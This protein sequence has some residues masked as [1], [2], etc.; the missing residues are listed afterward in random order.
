MLNYITY[1]APPEQQS[2]ILWRTKIFL[3]HMLILTLGYAD[4]ASAK[5]GKKV[6]ILCISMPDLKIQQTIINGMPH[7]LLQLS[8]STIYSLEESIV[9]KPQPMKR[10]LSISADSLYSDLFV[11]L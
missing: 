8:C 3:K 4:I 1:S 11:S 9:N 5:H 7:Y 2:Y 10:A 6:Q